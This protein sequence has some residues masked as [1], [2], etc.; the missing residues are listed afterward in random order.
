VLSGAEREEEARILAQL[1]A[2]VAENA[3]RIWQ[4]TWHRIVPLPSKEVLCRRGGR[5]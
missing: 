4:V 2:A 1:S 5:R 3:P